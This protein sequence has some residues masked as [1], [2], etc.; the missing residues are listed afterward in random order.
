MGDN[1]SFVS[2]VEDRV[3][4]DKGNPVRRYLR[5]GILTAA[6]SVSGCCI[7]TTS[8]DLNFLEPYSKCSLKGSQVGLRSRF[9][10]YLPMAALRHCL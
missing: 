3:K 10:A 8:S 1:D 7:S 2:R 5:N 6:V 9:S 4:N